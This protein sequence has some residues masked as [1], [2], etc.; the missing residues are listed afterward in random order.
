L[1]ALGSGT[2]RHLSKEIDYVLV[3]DASSR[4]SN[5]NLQIIIGRS[6]EAMPA[7]FPL[8]GGGTEQ[9]GRD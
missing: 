6:L 3:H 1:L 7:T 5:P 9:P 2:V 4:R 8:T